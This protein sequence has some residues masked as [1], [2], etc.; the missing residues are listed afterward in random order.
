MTGAASPLH[1]NADWHRAKSSGPMRKIA[2]QLCGVGQT[3]V[4]MCVAEDARRGGALRSSAPGGIEKKGPMVVK[5]KDVAP[6]NGSL[7]DF[8]RKRIADIQKSG[9]A[10]PRTNLLK[11]ILQMALTGRGFRMSSISFSGG[12]WRRLDLSTAGSGD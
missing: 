6:D 11:Y 4:S 10:I 8:L 9:R 1:R 2:S 3:S 7:Y 12:R 5:M